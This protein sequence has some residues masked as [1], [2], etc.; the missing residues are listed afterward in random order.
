LAEIA[1]QAVSVELIQ[2]LAKSAR[3]RL[4]NLGYGEKAQVR[5]GDGFDGW[6]GDAPFDSIIVTAAPHQ[7]PEKM[8]YQYR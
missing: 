8:V 5:H 3:N 1:F 6:P 4:D 2:D 7:L